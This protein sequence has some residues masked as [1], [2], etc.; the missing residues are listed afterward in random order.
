MFQVSTTSPGGG[1]MNVIELGSPLKC[2]RCGVVSTVTIMSMFN[3]DT[4]CMVCKQREKMHPKYNEAV[5]A[6]L[7]AV[8]S[9]DYN[10]PGIG[11]PGDL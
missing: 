6:E 3:T 5:T 7:E 11:K 4:I 8:R 2:A 1:G 10:F 9:G